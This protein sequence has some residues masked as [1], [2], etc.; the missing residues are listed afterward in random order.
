M[1]SD[2]PQDPGGRS[3][4][5]GDPYAVQA[6]VVYA[7]GD[8]SVRPTGLTVIAVISLL[9]GIGGA[10]FGLLG[11]VG[12]LAGEAIANAMQPSG[13]GME[14]QMQMQ[15]ELNSVTQK[16]LWIT[17]PLLLAGIV[18]AGCMAAGG[19]GILAKKS[20]ASKLLVRVFLAAIVVEILKTIAHSLSQL[21]IAPIMS[22]HM[23]AIAGNAD[24]PG[25]EM[26]GQMMQV[27][28]YVG[29]AFMFVWALAKIG[30]MIWARLYL[31]KP[32]TKAYL[33][34]AA[35]DHA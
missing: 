27:M 11:L 14:A 3:V 15:A 6:P 9:A 30:L 28:T 16:Y 23:G 31:N 13:P 21:E 7:E 29:L 32:A 33:D 26:M 22:K 4:P 35:S 10:L 18:I 34:A 19:I 17:L 8:M 1:N 2:F 5:S 20:W 12:M 25:G 24:N